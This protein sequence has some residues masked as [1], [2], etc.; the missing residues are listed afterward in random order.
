M[1]RA[2][3]PGLGEDIWREEAG[4]VGPGTRGLVFLP[5]RDRGS[6]GVREVPK[7]P[8]PTQVTQHTQ[9]ECLV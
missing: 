5:G 4:S 2:L 9:P 6:V 8:A 7:F 3:V 1:G